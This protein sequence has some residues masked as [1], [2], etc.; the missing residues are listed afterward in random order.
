MTVTGKVTFHRIN[1]TNN[2]TFLAEQVFELLELGGPPN[3]VYAWE[4]LGSGSFTVWS[5]TMRFGFSR[6][7]FTGAWYLRAEE[8]RIILSANNSYFWVNAIHPIVL[9]NGT[10]QLDYFFRTTGG[11]D[12]TGGT[13]RV[14]QRTAA[15][16]EKP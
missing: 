6:P 10:L 4:I 5:G 13:I 9:Q 11:I 3:D 2:G 14:A 1:V 7:G 16:F 8:G 12:F 15:M